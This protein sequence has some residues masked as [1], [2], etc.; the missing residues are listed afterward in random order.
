V[1][2]S[3]ALDTAKMSESRTLASIRCCNKCSGAAC[4]CLPAAHQKKRCLYI[5]NS[6]QR[7]PER[8]L[9][10]EKSCLKV[11]SRESQKVAS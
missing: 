3:T 4:P 8:K 11:E 9:K 7:S 6:G 10:V 1:C 2:L 5:Y